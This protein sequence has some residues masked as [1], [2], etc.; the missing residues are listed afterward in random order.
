MAST[1][2]KLAPAF[3]RLAQLH[4][5]IPQESY[6]D[7]DKILVADDRTR[8][9]HPKDFPDRAASI[10]AV[11]GLLHPL[12]LDQDMVILCGL[13]RRGTLRY[14][15]E[16]N[17]ETFATLFPTGIPVRIWPIR[18]ADNP[19]AAHDIELIEN[20]QRR[21]YTDAE[22][23]RIVI[24][25][26][27]SGLYPQRQGP[28]RPGER[29]LAD[30]LGLVIQKSHATVYRYLA[31]IRPEIQGNSPSSES[32]D[33]AEHQARIAKQRKLHRALTEAMKLLPDALDV[34]DDPSVRESIKPLISG[35]TK[36]L[37]AVAALIAPST[38]PPIIATPTH[39]N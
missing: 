32:T 36:Q 4:V 17:P 5:G 10:I 29:S 24:R 33:D 8:D 31:K 28:L 20:E 6:V 7:L 16:T 35:L 11:G 18:R 26:I 2:D 38:P 9:E 23:K 27:G 30:D 13:Q 34:V 3:D 25:M 19:S 37:N 21:D 22:L 39:D 14:L 1:T 15:R 12:V